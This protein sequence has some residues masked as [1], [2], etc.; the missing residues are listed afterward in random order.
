MAATGGSEPLTGAGELPPIR[1]VNPPRAPERTD[2]R[3]R[4]LKRPSRDESKRR[5]RRP[6]DDERPHIDEYARGETS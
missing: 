5:E 2:P 3:E 1:P 6:P 4:P